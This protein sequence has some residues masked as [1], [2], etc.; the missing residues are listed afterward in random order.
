METD[1]TIRILSIDAWR[2]GVGGWTWNNWHA[3]GSCPLSWCDY[4]PR[5]L[6]RIMRAEGYLRADSV[7]KCAVEDDQH[8]IVVTDRRNGMPVFALEYGPAI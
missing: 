7:G 8:N 3:V 5:K 4:S 1:K 6:L 2:D